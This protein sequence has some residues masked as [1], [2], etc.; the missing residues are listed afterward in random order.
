MHKYLYSKQK[1]NVNDEI[2]DDQ[3]YSEPF[4][5]KSPRPQNQQTPVPKCD[6]SL[7]SDLTLIPRKNI[8]KPNY[9][10]QYDHR[11]KRAIQK[12]LYVKI[13]SQ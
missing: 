11:I 3:W 13:I 5:E 7:V 6:M 1:S 12:S 10:Q 2:H 9:G 8:K 4:E